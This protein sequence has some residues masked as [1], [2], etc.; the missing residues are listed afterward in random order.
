MLA[1]T[2][3]FTNYYFLQGG[4]SH[5]AAY[6]TCPLTFIITFILYRGV[7]AFLFGGG[8][9]ITPLLPPP[10]GRLWCCKQLWELLMGFDLLSVQTFQSLIVIYSRGNFV[11]IIGDVLLIIV[12]CL[13]PLDPCIKHTLIHLSVIKVGKCPENL[14]KFKKYKLKI[15]L[16]KVC[17]E[18]WIISK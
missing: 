7:Q 11:Y 17:F 10:L 12:H 14:R 13:I 5:W 8:G 15:L 2:L 9:L 16:L 3:F 18:S 4:R 6:Y 1:F